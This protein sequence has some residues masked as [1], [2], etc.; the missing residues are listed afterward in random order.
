MTEKSIA[1]DNAR[2]LADLSKTVARAASNFRPPEQLTVTQ[3]ADKYRRLSP[4]NSAEPG[5]WKTGRTP[6]LEEIMDAFTDPRIHRIT[7]VASS[8]VGKTEAEL[9]MLGYAMDIDPGPIMFV[10]PNTR[11]VAETFSKRRVSAMI[12]DTPRL[13]KKV[14]DAKG[15]DG[16][17]TIFN[18][19]Y[20]GGMLTITGANS[21]SNLA[22]TPCRYV[23]GDER[24]RWPRSAGAEGDPWG[25]VKARTIT[26]YN[27]KMVEVSTPT[28]KGCSVIEES[29]LEGSQEY[30]STECPHCHE[31]SF[32]RFGNIR[33]KHT[34][35]VKNGKNQY[36]VEEIEYVC[37]VCGCISS[38]KE[39]RRQP[40]KWIAKN[41]EAYKRGH[42]SFWI[43][44]FSSPWLS[45]EELILRYLAA[46]GDPEELKTVYNTLFGELWEDRTG[47][48][49]ED[50]LLARREEYEAELPDGV[51]CLTCGVDTQNNRLEYEVVG[52]GYHRENWGIEKGVIMGKPDEDET[53]ERLDGVIDR[54][55][56]FKNGRGLKTSITFV[57]SGGNYT[58]EVYAQCKKRF[59]KKVFAI[60][61][62]NRENTPYISIPKLVNILDEEKRVIGKTWLYYIG[63]DAGKEKIMSGLEVQQ[64]GSRYS[65]FPLDEERGYD[66]NFASGLLSEVLSFNG[67]RWEWKKIPGHERNEALD[68]RNYANAAFKALNPNLEA[69][70]QKLKEEVPKKKT[71]MVKKRQPKRNASSLLEEEW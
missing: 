57:D 24:D 65:H 55:W 4:E 59:H 46:D 17:N 54:V 52:Y 71:K 10:L 39:I 1:E 29:F 70:E 45:W 38:E 47:L 22:S 61:G 23:F 53:W 21:P 42:R 8:Q 58:Q 9:N 13:R 56:K 41:P 14:A 34:K 7:V 27:Y 32:I 44:A 26:F 30:W 28:I 33:F 2:G 62:A 63:V 48:L 25:L 35:T 16:N 68:C 36:T 66:Y 69:I 6:Y 18:K 5:R 64:P 40:K 19:T 20:P 11:P 67:R 51:L 37:P 15:R 3:W 50:G 49:D 43:N 60:K 31:Y 12:R